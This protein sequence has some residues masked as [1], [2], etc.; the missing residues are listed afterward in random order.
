MSFLYFQTTGACKGMIF[1]I[2]I[3]LTFT[4]HEAHQKLL[5]QPSYSEK[6]GVELRSRLTNKIP[7]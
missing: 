6:I 1:A 4:A 2:A 5:Q 3:A 7:N